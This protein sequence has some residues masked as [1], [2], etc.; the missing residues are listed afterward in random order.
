MFKPWFLLMLALLSAA[1][2]QPA[3]V[4]DNDAAVQ[5]EITTGSDEGGAVSAAQVGV[6]PVPADVLSE[7]NWPPAQVGAGEA[8]ISCG[9]DNADEDV[10]EP[11]VSLEF[12]DLVDALTPCREQGV[13]R[14][15]YSG[16]IDADFTTLVERVAAMATRMEIDKRILDIDSAGGRVEDAMR[17]GD[18]IGGSHWTIRVREDALCHSACVLV[19][20]AGDS[21]L[22]SGKVGIHRMVRIGSQATSRIELSQELKEVH[23]HMKDY[24]ER[25][26][27]SVAVADLMMTVPSRQLRILTDVELTQFGL[28]NTNAAQDD[29]ERIQLTRKCGESFVRRKDAFAQAFD[30]ECTASE[31]GLEAMND[32]GLALEKRFGFPDAK[33]PAESPLSEYQ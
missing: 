12:F 11:L 31:P 8:L 13:V 20:A 6:R 25:N 17:A 9:P 26:G 33:C 2:S 29:L 23:T 16:K 22:I 7:T 10:G 24:L 19:L 32:C 4:T 28:Q 21:R 14:L 15:H 18:S 3:S 5:A 30:N 1:C 27:A